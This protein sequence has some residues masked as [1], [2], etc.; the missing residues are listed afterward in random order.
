MDDLKAWTAEAHKLYFIEKDSIKAGFVHLG[1]RGSSLNWLEDLFVL[2]EYQD[3]GIGTEAI[4][5]AEEI[6]KQYSGAFFI[7]AA[8][9]NIDAIR[10]YRKLGFDC[11]NT[12]TVCKDLKE[13]S[14]DVVKEEISAAVTS[15][16]ESINCNYQQEKN[17]CIRYL[18]E[19]ILA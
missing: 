15:K 2:P 14:Y 17:E 7:E 16:S 10:L 1:S 3:Q 13:Y 9:R 19:S 11:L 12:I 4:R 18:S 6:V 8:S 5:L